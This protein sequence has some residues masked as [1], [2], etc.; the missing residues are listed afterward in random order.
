MGSTGAVTA[1][2]ARQSRHFTPF[3]V[4]G[5]SVA[6]KQ[7][8][9]GVIVLLERGVLN[10]VLVAMTTVGTEPDDRASSPVTGIIETTGDAAAVVAC[11]SFASITR[12]VPLR[13][14]P[15]WR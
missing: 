1:V 15:R 13:C 14:A 2:A 4:V 8:T 12:R 6:I 10:A 11:Y 3:S 9:E 5:S 7:L